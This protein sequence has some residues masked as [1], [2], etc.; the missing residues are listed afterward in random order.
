ML[1]SSSAVNW[2]M[3]KAISFAS[4]KK[5]GVVVEGAF[6]LEVPA[7]VLAGEI[8]AIIYYPNLG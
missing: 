1:L 8:R 2:A 5:R 3:F 4:S 7:I 6:I